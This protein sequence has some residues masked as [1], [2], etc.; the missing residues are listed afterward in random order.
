[1]VLGKILWGKTS[2]G[3]DFDYSVAQDGDEFLGLGLDNDNQDE[4]TEERLIIWAELITEE[5]NG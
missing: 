2:E 3:Y 4:E 1:M 5:F